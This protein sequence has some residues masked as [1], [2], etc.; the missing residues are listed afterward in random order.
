MQIFEENDQVSPIYHRAISL[1]LGK[2]F[3]DPTNISSSSVICKQ[4]SEQE[5]RRR[6]L[7]A[8]EEEANKSRIIKEHGHSHF[9]SQMMAKFYAKVTAK[10]NNEFDNKENLYANVLHIEDAAPA[11]MEILSV[12]AA[13][14]K[15]IAPLVSSL[16][17]LADELV[18]LVNKPQYR[19]R[20]DVQVTD[21]TLALTYVGL[22]N[23]KL[24]MPT[25]MLKHWLPIS[26][27]PF[28]LMKRKL[29]NDAL[30]VALASQALAK[31]HELD[32]FT[33]F[34]AGMLSN[35]GLLAVTR[36]FLQTYNEMHKQELKTA[37]DERDKRLHDVL[38]DFDVSPEL[39][40]EQL[41][42]RS[43]KV[44]ADIVELMRFD[45]LNITETMFDLAY[46]TDLK[47]MS[48]IAKLVVKARAYVAF[49]S[50]AKDELITNDEAKILLSSAK[51]KQKEIA[52][53]KK[54][55]IDH[56]KLIFK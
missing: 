39:L 41:V 10:V 21:S 55:D 18:N 2:E 24:V 28:A 13:S 45:R 3:A 23:L 16:P 4:N 27:A 48:P 56:I 19:K 35:I 47:K 9:K 37:Y 36:C 12:K 53:L 51:L 1:A 54:S 31:E 11:I 5:N 14:I 8:V 38:V 26:T 17:W 42:T 46:V 49:R 50:L 6:E 43:S 29:W 44:A 33:A 22:E 52:L 20:A 30:S 25:F 34:T 32:P 7:L 40:H 15:R